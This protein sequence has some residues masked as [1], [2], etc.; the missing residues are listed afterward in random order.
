MAQCNKFF[1]Q[2]GI[3]AAWDGFFSHSEFHF[4]LHF[5]KLR[6]TEKPNLWVWWPLRFTL[7]FTLYL[8][9][10]NAA[11][12]QGKIPLHFACICKGK[13]KKWPLGSLG[14]VFSRGD[15]F[16]DQQSIF[17]FFSPSPSVS[18]LWVKNPDKIL[19]LILGP[20][21]YIS[22]CPSQALTLA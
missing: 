19:C 5:P 20:K 10:S 7:H 22:L 4:A 11:Q 14:W 18:P 9:V 6:G 15:C 3:I 12:T 1:S 2:S 8:W 21:T 13:P 16:C 17:F